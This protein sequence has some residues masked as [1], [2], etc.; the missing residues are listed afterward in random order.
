MASSDEVGRRPRISL[1]WAYSPS[2][3]PSSAHGC[4]CSGVRVAL[5]TVSATAATLPVRGYQGVG[6]PIV[7]FGPIEEKPARHNGDLRRY[8]EPDE[9]PAVV[10]HGAQDGDD[11]R[12]D[13]CA[14]ECDEDSHD[15]WH[16]VTKD[17]D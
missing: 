16:K 11:K 8:G 3:N 4:D 7:A 13:E 14:A 17:Q 5:L 10:Q 1:I 15:A 6:S 12:G 2:F 9:N